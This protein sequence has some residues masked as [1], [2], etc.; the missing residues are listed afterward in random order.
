MDYQLIEINSCPVC[1]CKEFKIVFRK[2]K[3]CGKQC[4]ECGLVYLSPRIKNLDNV[5]TDDRTSSTSKYYKFAIEA[6][7]KIF[8]KRLKIIEEYVK[9]GAFLDIGCSIGTFLELAKADG[10]ESIL[11]IEPNPNSALACREKGLAVINKFFDADLAGTLQ[12]FDAVYIGDVIEHLPEP[13]EILQNIYRILKPN[14]IVMIVTP[15]FDSLVA[16]LLQIKPFEHILYF[17]KPSIMHLLE[18]TE[19]RIEKITTTTRDRSIKAMA[20]STTFSTNK[21]KLF[22][23]LI[24]SLHLGKLIN[25]FLK[26]FVRDEI[27]VIARKK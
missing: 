25:F 16:R 18:M 11:G 21:G 15:N 4:G 23:K 5:Y 10:W 26:L 1:D 6:D 13:N 19:F 14:G 12:Q 8:A 2:D 20:Y 22:V 7:R 24:A 9:K 27:L 17:T 3:F